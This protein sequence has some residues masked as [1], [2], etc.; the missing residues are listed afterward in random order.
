MDNQGHVYHG[1]TL[2]L[3]DEARTQWFSDV[4]GS[5]LPD[6]Y[7]VARVEID[8]VSQLVHADLSVLV[9]L[10]V[11]RIGTTSITLREKI[12]SKRTRTLVSEA[13]TTAVLWDRT[14]SRPRHITN[15]ERERLRSI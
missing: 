9:E 12:R 8:Y 7:V 2:T 3:L 13:V 1:T 6:S 14:Q 11:E 4:L 10:A 15:D 5:D